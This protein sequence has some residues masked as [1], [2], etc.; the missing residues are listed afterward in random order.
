MLE[1]GKEAMSRLLRKA[2]PL[3][4]WYDTAV[5]GGAAAPTH[6][7]AGRRGCGR[8]RRT[9]CIRRPS[10]ELTP[11]VRPPC[12]SPRCTRPSAPAASSV[13]TPAPATWSPTQTLCESAASIAPKVKL[14]PASQCAV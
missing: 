8:L 7:R 2:T 11:C 6:A 1:K 12:R 3:S 5:S 9:E 4:A 10:M 13:P 14:A